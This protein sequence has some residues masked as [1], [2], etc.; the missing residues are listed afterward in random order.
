MQERTYV[1][2][3]DVKHLATPL[4]AHRLVLTLEATLKLSNERLVEQVLDSLT[5]PTVV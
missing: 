4:L 2:P 5:V 3:E 1:T